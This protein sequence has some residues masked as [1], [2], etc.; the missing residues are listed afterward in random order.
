MNP[1]LIGLI[2]LG[3]ALV[4]AT[5]GYLLARWTVQR[6]RP[7]APQV[8]ALRS[9]FPGLPEFTIMSAIVDADHDLLVARQAIRDTEDWRSMRD[10]FADD[11]CPGDLVHVQ[12]VVRDLDCK[13]EQWNAELGMMTR[14]RYVALDMVE[15]E[16]VGRSVTVADV[17]RA[18]LCAVERGVRRGEGVALAIRPS[19][20]MISGGRAVLER[21]M[22]DMRSRYGGTLVS[23]W[24][25]PCNLAVRMAFAVTSSFVAPHTHIFVLSDD[26]VSAGTCNGEPLSAGGAAMIA[27]LLGL[28]PRQV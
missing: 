3:S 4:L 9:E 26:D 20:A 1:W 13:D 12:G 10:D 24:A 19:M 17:S 5:V 22:H 11:C 25:A 14:G 6:A 7:S 16:R 23:V 28:R 27:K 15:W 2:A 8:V 21:V 18:T